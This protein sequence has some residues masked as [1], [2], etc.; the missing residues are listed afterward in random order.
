MREGVDVGLAHRWI[1]AD[2]EPA[3]QV[4]DDTDT[5]AR[6]VGDGNRRDEGVLVTAV[7]A[8]DAHGLPGGA[9]ALGQGA[10]HRLQGVAIVGGDEAHP[11]AEGAACR[12]EVQ[13][14]SE[15]VVGEGQGA[16][17]P[18]HADADRQLVHQRRQQV[19]HAT[20]VRTEGQ[21]FRHGSTR[22]IAWPPNP[23]WYGSHH[24]SLARPSSRM[25]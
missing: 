1:L 9:H 15:R 7:R 25:V 18:D 21:G 6:L 13:H 12:R 10:I 24:W 17:E 16:I 11:V 2:V 14:P 3:F 20:R 23:Q 8:P 19:A 22:G 4:D 5:V